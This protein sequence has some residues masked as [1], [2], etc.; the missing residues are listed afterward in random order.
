MADPQSSD[1]VATAPGGGWRLGS[2]PCPE[3]GYCLASGVDCFLSPVGSHWLICLYKLHDTSYATLIILIAVHS[4][5]DDQTKELKKC[6]QRQ[7]EIEQSIRYY[8]NMKMYRTIPRKFKPSNIP[9]TTNPETPLTDDFNQKYEELFFSH[10]DKV[11]V[12]D[13]LTLELTKLRI[14]NILA[15]TETHLSSLQLSPRTLSDLYNQFLTNNH[16]TDHTPLPVLQAKL[17]TTVTTTDQR[18]TLGKRQ[19]KDEHPSSS[20]HFL[21]LGP[22]HPPQPP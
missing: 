21:L 11:L 5:L 10:L 9:T 17:P 14:D 1:P 20:K 7:K 22:H 6:K 16:I 8:Q 2:S 3:W 4:F 19:R 12:S 15:Q 18:T 13:N